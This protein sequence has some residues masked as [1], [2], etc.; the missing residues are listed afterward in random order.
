[1]D[2][3]DGIFIKGATLPKHCAECCCLDDKNIFCKAYD[4]VIVDFESRPEACPLQ[5]ITITVN[6]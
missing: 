6:D 5:S 3:V 4:D 2:K 1:M